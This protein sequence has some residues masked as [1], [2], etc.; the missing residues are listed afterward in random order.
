MKFQNT[1]TI[2]KELFFPL[3]C[4]QGEGRGGGSPST[5]NVHR[6]AFAGALCVLTIL[7]TAFAAPST[8]PYPSPNSIYNSALPSLVVVQ[9]TWDMELGRHDMMGTGIVISKDGLIATSLSLINPHIPN[10]QMKDFKILVPSATADPDE[11]DAT[12]V[13]RDE[14]SGL[15]FVRAASPHK[16]TPMHFEDQAMHVGDT[17]YSVGLL[18]KQAG[19]RP[20]L[21]A[22]VISGE[23]HR[24]VPMF[25]VASGL[26]S[27]GSAVFDSA[28]HTVGLAL[29]MDFTQ[30]PTGGMANPSA[31]FLPSRDFLFSFT[32]LPTPDQEQK[33]PWIGVIELHG[34]TKD[35]NEYYGLKD[36][37]ALQIGD[38]IADT[39]ADKAGMKRGMIIVSMN[40]KPLERGD[41]AEQ[42]PAILH[43]RLLRTHIGD[44]ITFGVISSPG[45]APQ[46]LTL[47]LA[48]RPPSA[49]TA[50]RYWAED[51]GFGVRDAVFDDLYERH[52]PSNTGGVIVTMIKPQGSAMIARLSPEDMVTQVNGK[53]INNVEQFQ[54][55]YENL[56]KTKPTE[57]VLLVI[58]HEGNNQVIRIEPP[59]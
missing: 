47:T 54:K 26:A 32:D 21:T 10:A 51:L 37:P 28:G 42:I 36:Q 49:N 52:L 27:G 35:M 20:Y 2:V 5:F 43:E 25:M 55:T 3:P 38:V 11:I 58:V 39:P 9:F 44:K 56:R 57:A 8:A 19:Y 45:Q 31:F 24:Q 33:L 1:L 6:S 17:V 12:F 48:A 22:G 41:D 34:L 15:A 23:L 29:S 18:P 50:K 13:G 30:G 59:Q 4:T 16:W 40:G 7:S 14:R 53:P 46:N